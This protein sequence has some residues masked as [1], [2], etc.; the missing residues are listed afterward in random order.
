M[1]ASEER[2]HRPQMEEGQELSVLLVEDRT[3]D[4]ELIVHALRRSG[5]EV[6]WRRVET[7]EAFLDHL[8]PDLDVI[9]ADYALPQFDGLEALALLRERNMD[10]PFILISGTIGEEAAVRAMRAGASDYLLK[11]R[12]GR[13]PAAVRTVLRERRLRRQRQQASEALEQ[14]EERYRRLVEHSPAPI[15]VHAQGKIVY[16]N[17]AT[18]ALLG[19]E[20][21]GDLLGLPVLDL[22][23]EES[24]PLA[25]ERIRRMQQTGEPEPVVEEKIVRL[26]GTVIYVELAATPIS[27]RGQP[28]IQIIGHDITERKKAEEAE[29]RQRL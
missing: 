8:H 2:D 10:V 24:R 25:R 7:R 20:S 21:A 13:L 28:A 5:F 16:V 27:F 15:A 6:Q 12:L 23:H 18:V 3:D 4:A 22:L 9:L 11:D 19:A 29:H 26:D 1:T 14:S 17:P